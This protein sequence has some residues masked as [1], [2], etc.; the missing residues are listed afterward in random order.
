[1]EVLSSYKMSARDDFKEL[2]PTLDRHGYS[3]SYGDRNGDYYKSLEEEY[4]NFSVALTAMR[5]GQTDQL[6]VEERAIAS[7]LRR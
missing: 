6:N 4:Q 1:M 7:G 5:T 3:Y 2:P